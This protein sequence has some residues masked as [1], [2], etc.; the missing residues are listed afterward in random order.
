MRV[1]AYATVREWLGTR[2][3]PLRQRDGSSVREVLRELAEHSPTFGQKLWD[4]EERLSGLVV[5]LVNGRALE[6]APGGL[7]TRLQA[8]DELDLFPPVGGG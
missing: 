2:E 4:P 3:P 5:V 8:G 1:R 6:L 7:D